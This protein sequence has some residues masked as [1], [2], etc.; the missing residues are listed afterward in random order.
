MF[1]YICILLFLIMSVTSVFGSGKIY[2]RAKLLKKIDNSGQAR[3]IVKF[4]V[5]DI[6]RLT[7]RSIVSPSKFNR[8]ASGSVL[9]NSEIDQTLQAD[10]ALSNRIHTNATTIIDE[11]RSVSIGRIERKRILRTVPFMSLMVDID[12]LTALENDSRILQ[13]FEDKPMPLPKWTPTVS[14]I[15]DDNLGTPLLSTSVDAIKADGAWVDGYTGT[16]WYVAIM[17]TGLRTDHEMF[18]GKNIIEACRASG[19]QYENPSGDCPNGTTSQNGTGAAVHFNYSK[20]IGG[21]HGTHVAGIAAGQSNSLSGIAKDANI[22]AVNVFSRFDNTEG[23]CGSDSFCTLSWSSDQLAGLEYVYSLRSLYSIG[24]VNMSLGSGGYSVACDSDILSTI[25]YNLKSVGITTVIA[26]GNENLCSGVSNPACIGNAIAVGASDNTAV[27]TSFSNSYPGLVD[28]YAPG[29]GIA[30]AIPDTASSYQSWSGTSMAAPHVAGA[31]TLF[32]QRFPTASVAE[33]EVAM[34][35]SADGVTYRCVSPS[36]ANFIDV[37]GTM[38]EF[39]SDYPANPGIIINSGDASTISE[40]VI[41]SL[42]A[43]DDVGING[44]YV[45]ESSSTPASGDF[46]AVASAVN[47]STEVEFVLSSGYEAKTVYAWYKD[48]DNQI[49]SQ[50]F[51]TILFADATAPMAVD[52]IING[53]DSTTDLSNVLLALTATD[54]GGVTGYAIS[55]TD[56]P[57]PLSAFIFVSPTTSYSATVSYMLSSGYGDKMLYAWFRDEAGNISSSIFDSIVYVDGEAPISVSMDIEDGAAAVKSV[58]VQI[59]LSATDNMGVTGYYISENNIV[60]T[61]GEFISVLSTTSFSSTVSYT[62]SEGYGDKIIY[63]WF[64]DGQNNISSFIFDSVELVDGVAPV[65]ETF[66]INDGE[67]STGSALVELRF[68]A[69]DNIGVTGF[70]VTESNA[71]PTMD[72]FT[73]VV[74]SLNYQNLTEYALSEGYGLKTVYIWFID[75]EHNVSAA[76]SQQIEVV[77]TVAP[78]GVSLLLENGASIVDSRDILVSLSALDNVE[79][80]G[81][82]LSSDFSEPDISD[83]IAISFAMSFSGVT[84]YELSSGNGDKTVYAW[85]IDT[86]GNVSEPLQAVIRLTVPSNDVDESSGSSGGCSAAGGDS[87]GIY[88]L[89][90]LLSLRFMRRK[91]I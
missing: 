62:L 24:A 16:G 79:V 77:D 71:I 76:L 19:Y 58:D 82:Y 27:E 88:V 73:S 81:Y 72:L 12:G 50:A 21:D 51:D 83:F 38:N 68:T 65:G 37:I 44:Y 17:D 28:I 70:A 36:N 25:I 39:M 49:S 74:S 45:S 4:R 46:I 29:S 14:I 78:S 48:T 30:S 85:F 43:T 87:N 34:K 2:G 18:A 90:L 22:I 63:A 69:S 91:Q 80:A 23:Y 5:P 7:H 64:V 20:Y 67:P 26:T 13:V 86:S 1:R 33:V 60:P 47:F 40:N 42:T 9:S 66:L 31:W 54:S 56:T 84:N 35:T 10:T 53:G 32:R 59:S 57:P 55:E 6:D 8:A 3:V 11:I 61:V 41:L 52:F 15:N 89:L 75:A